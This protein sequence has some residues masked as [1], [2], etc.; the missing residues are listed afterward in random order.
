VVVGKH[1]NHGGNV[2]VITVPDG[3]PIWT[4]G[5]RLGREHDTTAAGPHT[6]ILPALTTAAGD[7]RALGDLGYE[8][9]FDTIMVAFQK[10]KHASLTTEQQQFNRAH[11]GLRAV[12]ERGNAI[13]KTTFRR[14]AT[15]ASPL[16]HRRH[17]RRSPRPAALRPRPYDLTTISD[18]QIARNGSVQRPRGL[19]PRCGWSSWW[20]SW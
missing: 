3:W 19:R 1:A 20:S 15:S 11:N 12:G 4:F 5:V 14:C 17:R 7:L 8:G 2:Q 18:Q 16:A 13:L 6:E 10:P 9:E